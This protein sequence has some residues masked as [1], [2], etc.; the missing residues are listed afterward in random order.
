[1]SSES[2]LDEDGPAGRR[3]SVDGVT[4]RV[5]ASSAGDIKVSS[6]PDGIYNHELTPER[7]REISKMFAEAAE[8]VEEL[9]EEGGADG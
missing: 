6:W 2:Y 9:R 7:L 8:G 5:T 3:Y 1:M 4:V